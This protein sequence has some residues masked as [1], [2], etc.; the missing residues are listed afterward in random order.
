MNDKR[1]VYV[2][3]EIELTPELRAV[4][5]VRAAELGISVEEC[6]QRIVQERAQEI[7]DDMQEEKDAAREVD[8]MLKGADDSK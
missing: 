8:D 4:I 2:E 1:K 5:A 6:L 7:V 3:T